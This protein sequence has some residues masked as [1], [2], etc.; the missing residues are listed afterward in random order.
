[1]KNKRR[2]LNMKIES[3]LKHI[4]KHQ[5]KMNT[6]NQTISKFIKEFEMNVQFT[7]NHNIYN[8]FVTIFQYENLQ[9]G[10]QY[11]M[12]RHFYFDKEE[13]ED[14]EDE[15]EEGEEEYEDI[16]ENEEEE[17]K[18]DKKKVSIRMNLL[19][20][21]RNK[22][23]EKIMKVLQT[24]EVK[25]GK[26]K[27]KEKEEKKSKKQIEIPVRWVQR[28]KKYV[29]FNQDITFYYFIKEDQNEIWEEYNYENHK[30]RSYQCDDLEGK[31]L[32]DYFMEHSEDIHQTE[33]IPLYLSDDYFDVEFNILNLFKMKV[34]NQSEE[35]YLG[36]YL[37]RLWKS[38]TN[39]SV[40]DSFM[41]FILNRIGIMDK[42]LKIAQNKEKIDIEEFLK[43]RVPKEFDINQELIHYSG[44]LDL[45]FGIR[46]IPNMESS[47]HEV[48]VFLKIIFNFLLILDRTTPHME[49]NEEEQ[50]ELESGAIEMIDHELRFRE[51]HANEETELQDTVE[52]IQNVIHSFQ[53]KLKTDFEE[54]T[55]IQKEFLQ[56]LHDEMDKIDFG[57][58][59][60]LFNEYM[61]EWLHTFYYDRKIP[62]SSF[63]LYH[64][65]LIQ[66]FK[67]LKDQSKWEKE[68]EVE[69]IFLHW[70]SIG[71]IQSVYKNIV[72]NLIQLI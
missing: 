10:N 19:G 6:L 55:E 40:F 39:I 72:G 70:I 27:G 5:M 32:E 68:K 11:K 38:N 23:L 47:L 7:I 42:F 56:L 29:N 26:I 2:R 15:E 44:I 14:I 21:K 3:I 25:V 45:D 17:I 20:E 8:S 34:P 50:K 66:Q 57:I 58:K 52:N 64:Q 53:D 49:M 46:S 33:K 1:M 16:E 65:Q 4:K 37:K 43:H 28:T 60:K 69:N 24:K 12:I 63:A 61:T 30:L 67:I 48:G 13:E 54:K 59:I 36:D 31:S 22:E 51:I 62:K 71:D 35:E 9:N 18:E 41:N